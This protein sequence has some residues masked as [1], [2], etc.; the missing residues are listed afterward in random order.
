MVV[1]VG[2]LRVKSSPRR[3]SRNWP[4][5]FL[6][7]SAFITLLLA[8]DMSAL[9]L[10]TPSK[11][12]FPPFPPSPP[13][14]PCESFTL[15]NATAPRPPFPACRRIV[16]S[17]TNISACY[18]NQPR[19]RTF[20]HSQECWNVLPSRILT[21]KCQFLISRPSFYLG[22]AGA[23][24]RERAKFLGM[25]QNHRPA[26]FGVVRPAFCS[27]I[28]AQP[29]LQIIRTPYVQSFIRTFKDVNKLHR[30]LI[31]C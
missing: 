13:T 24:T 10:E 2:I 23:R 11:Y 28:F 3:P 14:G 8:Y 18:H 25:F 22:L 29:F 31:E 12:T 15:L 9:M 5:P 6:P 17:S 16:T 7:S 4:R 1:P 21:Q 26:D 27:E 20:Q 19:F 30:V